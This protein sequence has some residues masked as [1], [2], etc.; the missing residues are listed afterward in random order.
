MSIEMKDVV[1]SKDNWDYGPSWGLWVQIKLRR[2]AYIKGPSGGLFDF[3]TV[4]SNTIKG[5]LKSSW[6]KFG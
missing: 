1:K 3:A 5:K 6:F 4:K 2:I